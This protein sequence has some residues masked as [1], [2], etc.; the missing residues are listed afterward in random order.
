[1]W[2]FHHALELFYKGG[3][4]HATG[5]LPPL[6]KDGHNLRTL[7]SSFREHFPEDQYPLGDYT[8]R[9]GQTLKLN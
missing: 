9:R 2:L 3:I 5:K 1:M 6:K 7:Q 4:V 8:E